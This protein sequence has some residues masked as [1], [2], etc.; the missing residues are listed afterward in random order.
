MSEDV[1]AA[2]DAVK[3]LGI[4]VKSIKIIVKLWKWN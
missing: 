4:K 1:L 3:K 2:L